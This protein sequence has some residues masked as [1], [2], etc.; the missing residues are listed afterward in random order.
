MFDSLKYKFKAF[1]L[2]EVLIA[3]VVIG[4][5][6]AI[7]IPITI[8]NYNEAEKI[9]K[10]KKT[11][12]TLNNAISLSIINGGTDVFEVSAN[13]FKTVQKYFDEYLK[14]RLS[15]T[16]VC[17]N[18]KGCWHSGDT[19][20]LNGKNTVYYNRTGVGVGADIITAVLADGTFIC[21]DVY[22]S[23]SIWKYF[24]TK[25]K[26]N[27]LVV[28]FDINGSRKPNIVGKDIFITISTE[29]GL[30]PVWKDKTAAEKKKDCSKSGTGYSCINEYL[31]K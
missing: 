28:W 14:D 23:A 18:T 8:A 6:A 19:K 15:T 3:L 12:S 1:S 7:T 27:G 20:E 11:Y 5:V 24:G 22:G 31:R 21:V 17:Y 2:A 29:Q 30:Y 4:V 26:N 9:A 25:V 13:D 10:I 16:K